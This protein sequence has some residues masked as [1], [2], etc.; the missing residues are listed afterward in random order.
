MFGMRVIENAA[1]V[2]TVEDWSRVRSPG[3]ARRRRHKHRQNIEIVYVPKTEFYQIGDAI[4][5]H[6]VMAAKLRAA[7]QKKADDM[8]NDLD[9]QRGSL[10]F[11]GLRW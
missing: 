3:R 8:R 4:M 2:D 6:P 9:H 7:A 5:C 11:G 10:L 1:L